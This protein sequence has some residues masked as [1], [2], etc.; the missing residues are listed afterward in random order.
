[1]FEWSLARLVFLKEVVVADGLCKGLCDGWMHVY[2]VLPVRSVI[3]CHC[4]VSQAAHPRQCI[5]LMQSK[6]PMDLQLS[7]EL[8][9]VCMFG[10]YGSCL[11]HAM[12]D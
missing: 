12:Q 6:D 5:A 10:S 9:F 7:R 8:W 11:V 4:A 2:F 1:M 3:F